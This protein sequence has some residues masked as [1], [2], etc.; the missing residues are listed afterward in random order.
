VGQLAAVSLGLP[1]DGRIDARFDYQLAAMAVI[2]AESLIAGIGLSNVCLE[3]LRYALA[4]PT[5]SACRT[6][7]TLRTAA[8]HLFSRSTS[9]VASRSCR[10]ARSAGR[11]DRT[12]PCSLAQ[13]LRAAWKPI[14]R[15]RHP[16]HSPSCRAPSQL[17]V[18]LLGLRLAA[19]RVIGRHWNPLIGLGRAAPGAAA[20]A[21]VRLLLVPHQQPGNPY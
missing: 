6:Y 11:A 4:G 20:D 8:M 1:G 16:H 5:S 12:T 3:Q 10:S 21:Q 17:P 9:A 19:S 7:F 2:C 13:W 14:R 18:L 15:Y